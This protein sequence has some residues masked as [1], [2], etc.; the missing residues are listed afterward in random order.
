MPGALVDRIEFQRGGQGHPLDDVIVRCKTPEG[1]DRCLE[2]QVKRSMA[3]TKTDANFASIMDA[4]VKARKIEPHRRFAVAIER[5]TGAIDNGVQEALELAQQTINVASFLKLLETPGRSNKDM[6]AFVTAFRVHLETS[7]ETGNDALYDI[8][9][10][11]SVLTFDYARP[12]SIAEQHDRFRAGQ[13]TSANGGPD[14][15]DGLFGLVLRADATG[16][17]LDRSELVR[18]LSAVGIDIGVAPTLAVARRHIEE[19]SR[20]ALDDIGLT[21]NE[22]R[23]AREK[24]RRELEAM[25]QAAETHDGVIEVSG[26]SGVGK[27]GLLR[28]VVEGRGAVSR[29]LVLAPDRALPGGWPA[30]RSQF[31]IQATADEFLSDLACDG[32][33][34][35]CIDGLDRFRDSAQRKTVLD[36]L[37]SALRCPGMTVLFTARPGWEEEAATWIGEEIFGQLSTRRRLALDGLDDEEAEALAAASPQLAHLLKPDHP[38]KPLT[39][40]Y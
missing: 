19:L 30:M 38:A 37:R 2:V 10:S 40:T 29:V 33:G 20:H 31:D 3:F 23:L 39:E 17:E 24:P 5:T 18:K 36:L 35:L 16:G 4:I 22:C 7:G 28:T 14:P 8:L 34:Y 1:E 25:L 21:V 26:P 9:R 15:Y 27:S 12:N 11:F 32:G 6:R 13:L